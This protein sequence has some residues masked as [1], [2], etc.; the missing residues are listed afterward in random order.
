MDYVYVMQSSGDKI[1]HMTKIRN[2]SFWAQVRVGPLVDQELY[3]P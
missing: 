1:S 2:A 3:S